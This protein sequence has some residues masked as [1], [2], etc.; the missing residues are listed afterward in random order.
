MMFRMDHRKKIKPDLYVGDTV[1]PNI[2]ASG[3]YRNYNFVVKKVFES[4]GDWYCEVDCPSNQI[5]SGLKLYAY[6]LNLVSRAG[7]AN[8]EE[9]MDLLFTDVSFYEGDP[10]KI[11]DENKK[12][13]GL[14]RTFN[15]DELFEW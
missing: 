8:N 11:R 7:G 1:R 12:P 9:V 4:A 10:T 6:K 5:Y 2:H 3:T 13:K 14:K 15:L